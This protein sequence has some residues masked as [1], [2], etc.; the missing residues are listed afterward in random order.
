MDALPGRSLLRI[1][2]GEGRNRQIRRM[3]EAIGHPVRRLV[4]PAGR[5][6]PAWATCGRRSGAT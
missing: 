2:I 4:A 1:V 3:C 6:R 5:R